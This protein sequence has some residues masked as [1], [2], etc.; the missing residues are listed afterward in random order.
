MNTSTIR[1]ALAVA[2]GLALTACTSSADSAPE[3]GD[4]VEVPAMYGH[5]A[6]ATIVGFDDD[7]DRVRLFAEY[8]PEAVEDHV[9]FTED[10]RDDEICLN[11]VAM[12]N[13]PYG[14][15]VINVEMV[16]GY[17]DDTHR[18]NDRPDL[19]ATAL[20]ASTQAFCV[21]EYAEFEDAHVHASG[22]SLTVFFDV[23]ADEVHADE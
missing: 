18:V 2:G 13:L 21:Q 5:T 3:V 8:E 10:G 6:E 9:S 15:E 16:P 12:L 4:A 23:P 14:S 17:T 20:T 1:K 11:R 7:R 22:T 19:D